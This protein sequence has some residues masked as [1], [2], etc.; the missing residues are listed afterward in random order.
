[1][2]GNSDPSWVRYTDVFFTDEKTAVLEMHSMSR[3]GLFVFGF[4]YPAF[5]KSEQISRILYLLEADLKK[6]IHEHGKN[7]K[8]K[9]GRSFLNWQTVLNENIREI[10]FKDY[11]RGP[12]DP[13]N[14][15][16]VEDKVTVE[17]RAR[18]LNI[19]RNLRGHLRVSNVGPYL[20]YPL[21]PGYKNICVSTRT[22]GKTRELSSIEMG[23]I[24][25][26]S[27]PN[28]YTLW[29]MCKIKERAINGDG[30]II[31]NFQNIRFYKSD[32]TYRY[33]WKTL[34]YYWQGKELN[35]I[36]ARREIFCP[37]Y[38][39]FARK[40][41]SFRNIKKLLKAG[42]NVQLI[43]YDSVPY[44]SAYDP[45]GQILKDIFNEP[46]KPF[47]NVHVLAGM[48]TKNHVWEK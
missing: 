36:E 40:T 7:P 37:L 48:L 13:Y 28:L 14:R 32:N 19:S 43:G 39:D 12:Y 16:S 22:T 4:Y 34:F 41:K 20:S 6:E 3:Q 38:V 11:K 33:E 1:M 44:S 30:K 2:L 31:K 27:A 17:E 45:V 26:P 46:S 9:K 35:E 47:T 10:N 8:S 23:P 5:H 25:S 18:E 24:N 15:P 21:G 42:Y 29:N